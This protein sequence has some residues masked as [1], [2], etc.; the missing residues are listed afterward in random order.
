M[1]KKLTTKQVAEQL[2]VGTPRVRQLIRSGDLA[3]ERVFTDADFP[4]WKITPQAVAALKRRRL[5]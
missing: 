1:S 2:G 3:A 5:K 4:Q